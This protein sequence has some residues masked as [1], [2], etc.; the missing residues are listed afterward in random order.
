MKSGA[1]T[2]PKLVPPPTPDDH[3][4]TSRPSPPEPIEPA[5]TGL[6]TAAKP[7]PPAPAP[8][9]Q[10]VTGKVPAPARSEG[11]AA[12]VESAP[13]PTGASGAP[14]GETVYA[15]HVSSYETL[16]QA[17]KDIARLGKL[18]V[19]ARAVKTDLGSKGVWYRVYVGSYPTRVAA[20]KAR[21]GILKL[22]G[23]DYAQVRPLSR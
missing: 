14:A 22:P 8:S 20:E 12:P 11:P 21:E 16:E 5:G 3:A 2:R 19:E 7:A 9:D 17:Y 10:A 15:V 1:E 6:E 13:A 4:A 18:G 23:I